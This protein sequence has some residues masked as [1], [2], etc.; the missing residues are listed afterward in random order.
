M[1]DPTMMFRVRGTRRDLLT[2]M[3]PEIISG[4][5]IWVNDLELVAEEGSRLLD[6]MISVGRCTTSG[7]T[8]LLNH[9]QLEILQLKHLD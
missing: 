3:T 6:D 2:L 1:N 4:E 8:H 5:Q 9:T 7:A